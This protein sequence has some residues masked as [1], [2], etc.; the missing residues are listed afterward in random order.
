MIKKGI[1]EE[2]DS[3]FANDIIMLILGGFQTNA[4]LLANNL[5][6]ATRFVEKRELI[7]KEIQ[8]RILKGKYLKEVTVEDWIEGFSSENLDNMTFTNLFIHEVLRLAPSIAQSA[9][10]TFSE[11]SYIGNVFIT[12]D[13]DIT[14]NIQALHKDPK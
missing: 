14:L 1:Y 9:P 3:I 13:V 12:K 11:D 5:Y 7:R 8:E 10:F 2:D 6:Y 4:L